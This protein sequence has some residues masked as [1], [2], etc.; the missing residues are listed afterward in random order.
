M[1]RM[2]RAV[3]EGDSSAA[4]STHVIHDVEEV[5]SDDSL[6]DVQ[7]VVLGRNAE[8]FLG[9]ESLAAVKN[10]ISREGGSLVCARGAPTAQVSQRLNQILP[11]S[12]DAGRENRFRVSMTTQG[13]DLRWLANFADEDVLG[14]MPSLAAV[15]TARRRGLA[16]VLASTVATESAAG[17]ETVP[18]LSYQPYGAGRTVVVEGAGMW[19][20]ALMAPEHEK[21]RFTKRCGEVCCGGWCREL[22]CRQ[23][24][25]LR[26]SRIGLATNPVPRPRRRC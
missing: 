2:V 19:R 4:E 11:V 12:W 26:C 14:A 3:G 5:L 24:K 22:V 1:Q 6:A 25:T 21:N 16:S 7:V 13:K 10:W 23:G 9:D 20:W 8:F 15:A 17:D 18:V